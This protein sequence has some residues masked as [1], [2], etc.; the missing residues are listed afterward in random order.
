[1]NRITEGLR[2]LTLL[3]NPDS[4][5]KHSSEEGKHDVGETEERVEQT[6]LRGVDLVLAVDAASE[7]LGIVQTVVAS[8]G[9]EA[10]Q[11][12]QHPSPS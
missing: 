6:E 1:M 11:H 4:V 7:S 9:Q 2:S 12:Q 10:S 5:N 8:K 3:P